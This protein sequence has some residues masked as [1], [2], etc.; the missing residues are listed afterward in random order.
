MTRRGRFL[1]IL[2]S[3]KSIGVGTKSFTWFD[4]M[5]RNVRIKML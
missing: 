5:I 4:P 3:E 2:F 1:T